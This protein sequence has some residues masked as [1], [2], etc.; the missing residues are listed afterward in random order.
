VF[1]WD[2][3]AKPG[4]AYSPQFVPP[5]QGSG[6]F[7]LD[8]RPPVLY[9]AE[10]AAHAIAEKLQRYRGQQIDWP[11]LRESGHPLAVVQ[12]QLELGDRRIADLCNPEELVRYELRPDVLMSR[13]LSLT[14]GLSRKLHDAGV[15]GFRVWSA[16][17]GDWHSTVL[18]LDRADEGR[19][20]QF[21]TPRELALD[22]PE[23]LEMARVLAISVAGASA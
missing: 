21:G 1:P 5:R 23:L 19:A 2:R 10:S 11:E 15:A 12:I 17:T 14:Q 9:L 18:F 4:D 7:D 22:S 8:G 6:R 16:L 13:D 3:G 20:M